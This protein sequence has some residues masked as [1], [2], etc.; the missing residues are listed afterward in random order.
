MRTILITFLL[1][2]I[3]WLGGGISS[4]ATAQ[5]A[6]PPKQAIE[7]SP[8]RMANGDTSSLCGKYE[9]FEDRTRKSGR[10][11]AL[12]IVILPALTK[13]PEADP[14]FVLAG[15]PGTPATLLASGVREGLLRQ[16][17]QHRAA[18]FVDQ[19]GTGGSNP[20]PCGLYYED[21]GLQGYLSEYFHRIW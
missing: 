12:N 7:L 10:K 19:R 2:V 8:C 14:V 18:V 13:T 21:R 5:N 3:G 11:I 4:A 9:V 15:G 16:L 17:R 20:L 1:I 6:A